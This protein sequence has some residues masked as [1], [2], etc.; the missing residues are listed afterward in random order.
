MSD[1]RTWTFI[2]R[3]GKEGPDEKRIF[4]QSELTIDGEMQIF[5]L[6]AEAIP[7][8]QEAKFPFDQLPALFPEKAEDFGAD[9]LL[10]VGG[11]ATA[12]AKAAPDL[13]TKA[14]AIVLG[15]HPRDINGK[16]NAD[17]DDQMLFLRLSIHTADVVEMFE[18]FLEQNDIERLKSPLVAAW[19]KVMEAAPPEMT[20]RLP[21]PPVKMPTMGTSSTPSATPSTEPSTSLSQTDTESPPE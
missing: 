16:P 10:A 1:T 6:I 12:I 2:R 3:T 19:Q 20:E 15:I 18:T 17:Y 11:M 14:T 5:G 21:T 8:L 9:T 7:I 4:Q 13:I